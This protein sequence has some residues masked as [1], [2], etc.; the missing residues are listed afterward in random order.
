MTVA[1]RARWEP[2]LVLVAALVVFVPGLG[3]SGLSSTEG[4]RAI[5][6]WE[7]LRAA[8]GAGAGGGVEG[9]EGWWLVPTMFGQAY[10][11]KPPGM[12]WAIAGMSGVLGET[13]F[14]ARLVSAMSTGLLALG[15]MVMARRWFG[16]RNGLVAGLGVVLMPLLWGPGRSAEIEALN[17]VWSAMGAWL[18][19]DVAMRPGG[20]WRPW[21]AGGAVLLAGLAKGPAGMPVVLAAAAAGC[22]AARSWRVGARLWPAAVVPMVGLGLMAWMTA[23]ALGGREPVT[24]EMSEFFWTGRALTPGSVAGVVL[25]P[26]LALLS[27]MPGAMA[28]LTPW[29]AEARERRMCGVVAGASVMSLASLAVMGV[30]N[31]RYGM[32]SVV[33]LVVLIGP[34][35]YGVVGRV[36]DGWMRW[37]RVGA[38]AA[39][40]ALAAVVIPMQERD[41]EK[42]SGRA[43]GEALA[44]LVGSGAVVRAD[45][46]V[47]ARPDVLWYAKQ[48]AERE[49]RGLEVRWT[50]GLGKK[51]ELG[52]GEYGCVRTDTAEAAEMKQRMEVEVVGTGS[53][54]QY[55]YEVVRRAR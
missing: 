37:W 39:M 2:L 7:M 29:I 13:E 51:G 6:G 42:R 50:P 41:R 11:R 55:R 16:G 14:A 45:H 46:L 33:V 3:W 25:M 8:R 32:P 48:R 26:M 30:T 18:V 31:P 40:G 34:L 53:I 9:V 52:V 43:A 22:V 38:H 23:R 12:P 35:L 44:G 19:I 20:R 24:Q 54:R 27:G 21:A 4:H 1:A 49:G 5:P 17:N 10:L 28:V 36:V 47:E 15:A